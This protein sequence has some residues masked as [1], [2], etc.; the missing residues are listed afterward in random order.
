[1]RKNFRL[2]L[3]KVEYVILD[4]FIRKQLCMIWFL[5]HPRVNLRIICSQ[6]PQTVSFP[7]FSKT[8]GPQYFNFMLITLSKSSEVF[9]DM[10]DLII[11]D[12]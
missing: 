6:S 11:N 9:S 8:V 12:Q 1:M 3:T 5:S 2:Y 7:C 10:N 4:L